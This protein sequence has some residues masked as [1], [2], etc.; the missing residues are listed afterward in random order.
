MAEPDLDKIRKLLALA[1]GAEGTAEGATAR[2]LAE[3]RLAEGGLT[4]EEVSLGRKVVMEKT[5]SIWEQALMEGCA[6][7]SGVGLEVD[8]R[9][10]T[11]TLKGPMASTEEALDRF[12]GVRRQLVRRASAY[13]KAVRDAGK[14]VWNDKEVLKSATERM[15]RV[16]LES[17]ALTVLTRMLEQILGGGTPD[18]EEEAPEPKPFDMPADEPSRKKKP[19]ERLVDRFEVGSDVDW[20]VEIDVGSDIVD[21]S[22]AGH[23]AGLL[24]STDPPWGDLLAE[25]EARGK[26]TG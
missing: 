20:D 6:D 22:T 9:T 11:W 14:M 18:E 5:A 4:E 12:E 19:F 1:R 7:L 21:P 8:R 26:L 15:R 24:V 10:S 17:A 16:F 2:A 13:V 23:E 3:R 25:T